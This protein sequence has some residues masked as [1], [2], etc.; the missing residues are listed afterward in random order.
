LKGCGQ[1]MASAVNFDNR[2]LAD[3]DSY[4]EKA[5]KIVRREA[6]WLTAE[7]IENI[8]KGLA[9]VGMKIEVKPWV[10]SGQWST[11]YGNNSSLCRQR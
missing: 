9:K 11:S 5:I 10:R 4:L 1:G 7:Q 6:G 3:L 2:S 8:R